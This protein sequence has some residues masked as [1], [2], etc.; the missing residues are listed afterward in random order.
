ML[1]PLGLVLTAQP[2]LFALEHG[3]HTTAFKHHAAWA[4]QAAGAA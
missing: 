2:D 3:F 1:V 4:A